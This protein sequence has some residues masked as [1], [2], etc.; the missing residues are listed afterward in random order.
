MD[1]IFDHN[2]K[3]NISRYPITTSESIVNQHV[4]TKTLSTIIFN[5]NHVN[6]LCIL[7]LVLFV[8]ILKAELSQ[9]DH[10]SKIQNE[11]DS[12]FLFFL[13]LLLLLDGIIYQ[14]LRAFFA[15]IL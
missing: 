5:D 6:V 13:I 7:K 10:F 14:L 8:K 3:I 12:S 15:N 4:A 9:A 2:G 1:E 11:T